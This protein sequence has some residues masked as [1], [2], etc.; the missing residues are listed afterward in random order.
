MK[1]YEQLIHDLEYVWL[2]TDGHGDSMEP[3]DV[4]LPRQLAEAIVEYTQEPSKGDVLWVLLFVEYRVDKWSLHETVWEIR[5]TPT[6]EETIAEDRD[7]YDRFV[8]IAKA[9][10]SNDSVFQCLVDRINKRFSHFGGVP[11]DIKTRTYDDEFIKQVLNTM[12]NNQT[13]T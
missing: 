5:E 1:D 13:P 11:D 4:H 10:V 2:Y 8:A 3:M 6:L 9:N 7:R 12:V